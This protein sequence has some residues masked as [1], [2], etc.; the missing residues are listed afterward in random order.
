MGAR[1]VDGS[2]PFFVGRIAE[3]IRDLLDLI[4]SSGY[5]LYVLAMFRVSHPGQLS[6]RPQT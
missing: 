3:I 4:E 2:H 1:F 6:F 5:R